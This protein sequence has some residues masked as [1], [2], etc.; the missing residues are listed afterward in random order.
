MAK[1]AKIATIIYGI[2]IFIGLIM[3][4]MFSVYTLET[5][6]F[7]V[8]LF[9]LQLAILIGIIICSL[10]GINNYEKPNVFIIVLSIL[11]LIFY[12]VVFNL[13][14]TII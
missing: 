11:S 4:F 13:P 5:L 14:F 3:F 9:Y 10:I 6:E 7:L 1:W 8:L 12:I 2:H